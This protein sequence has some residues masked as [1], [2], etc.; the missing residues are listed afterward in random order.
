MPERIYAFYYAETQ[1][2]LWSTIDVDENGLPRTEFVRADSNQWADMLA[3]WMVEN[4]FATGHGTSMSGLL[5][6]L[7]WQI[8]ELRA[9]LAQKTVTVDVYAE[10]VYLRYC[11][12][13]GVA[14]ADWSAVET[15]DVWREK[16]LELISA[17]VVKVKE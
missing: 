6:E 10:L 14:G 3:A 13:I 12:S 2:Q 16:A 11:H 9:D 4:G 7:T 8:K 15:K 5:H 1:D 17:G